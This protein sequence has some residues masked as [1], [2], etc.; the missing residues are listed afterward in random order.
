MFLGKFSGR[1]N[2]L[3]NLQV[4]VLPEEP[5]PGQPGLYHLLLVRFKVEG[6]GDRQRGSAGGLVFLA[7]LALRRLEFIFVFDPTPQSS[8]HDFGYGILIT[9]PSRVQG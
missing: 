9:H 3:L 1:S 4:Q 8:A 6:F 5:S 2:W 7:G